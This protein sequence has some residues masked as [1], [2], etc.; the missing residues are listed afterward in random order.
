MEACEHCATGCL[1]GEDMKLMTRCI[2]LDRSCADVC[3]FAARE[4]SRE[5]VW[6][7][8]VCQLCAEI[9]DACDEECAKHSMEHCQ[10]CA[11]ACRTCAEA[12]RLM[13]AATS[14]V[15]R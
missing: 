8:A 10:I 4:M 11:E 15:F 3:L 13:I 9:C 14:S 1:H 2:E 6:V 12:C 7:G 5:S